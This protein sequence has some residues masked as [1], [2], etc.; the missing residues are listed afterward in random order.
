M[1]LRVD[2]MGSSREEVY[3]LS[4]LMGR[5][6]M[7]DGKRVVDWD[8]SDSGFGNNP[9]GLPFSIIP[10][11]SEQPDFL[12]RCIRTTIDHLSQANAEATA[13]EVRL[14]ELTTYIEGL[15]TPTALTELAKNM[16]ATGANKA[17]RA[18]LVRVGL[19]KGYEFNPEA[20]TFTDPNAPKEEETPQGEEGE[21]EGLAF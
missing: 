6:F 1:K 8:P 20:R 5:V 11:P 15:D 10:P 12:A 7:Q 14:R 21:Q 2:A 17:D 3:K 13:E 18:I 9:A 4:D 19:A 16:V